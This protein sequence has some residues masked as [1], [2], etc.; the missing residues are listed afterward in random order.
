M[1]PDEP[2]VR[3][4]AGHVSLRANTVISYRSFSVSHTLR[5]IALLALIPIVWGLR[6]ILL[7]RVGGRRDA[8]S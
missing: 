6:I 3:I 2:G 7:R 5:R 1:L 8:V 4:I